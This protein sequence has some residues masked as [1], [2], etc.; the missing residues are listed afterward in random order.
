MEKEAK[1]AEDATAIAPLMAKIIVYIGDGSK[2]SEEIANHIG[3][4]KRFVERCASDFYLQL[5]KRPL[6]LFLYLKEGR[7]NL[8]ERGAELI[9]NEE[10]KR[11][12]EEKIKNWE[13]A[14]AVQRH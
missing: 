3:T 6:D 11:L 7:Y 5:T 4:S 12:I 14:L 9:K 1:V 2:T 10:S 8:S 13:T